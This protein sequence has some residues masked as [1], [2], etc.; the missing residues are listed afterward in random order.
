MLA[1]RESERGGRR[2]RRVRRQRRV[3]H[4]V[5]QQ[6]EAERP[7][8]ERLTIPTSLDAA[9]DGVYAIAEA[10]ASKPV[11]FFGHSQKQR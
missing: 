3:H 4:D 10:A 8:A 11:D 7:S 9:A 2:L 5:R 6:I 1:A